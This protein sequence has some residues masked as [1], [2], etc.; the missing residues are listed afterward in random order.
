[1]DVVS[2]RL[3]QKPIRTL[4]ACGSLVVVALYLI[5]Q[6]VGAGK[7][8]QLLFGLHSHLPD[9]A[10]GEGPSAGFPAHSP[11]GRC[12]ATPNVFPTLS[13]HL[14]RPRPFTL[15]NTQSK[16]PHAFA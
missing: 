5:A 6:M 9:I 14:H 4:S 12:Q 7:L 1:A 3:K 13:F 8:I 15:G 10:A 2:Y 16:K 11:S